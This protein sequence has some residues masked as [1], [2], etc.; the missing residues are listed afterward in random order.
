MSSFLHPGG[1]AGLVILRAVADCSLQ[2]W[3]F[4]TVHQKEFESHKE[5]PKQFYFQCLSG[6]AHRHDTGLDSLGLHAELYSR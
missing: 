1:T 2:M 6:Y 5:S 4:R 3:H